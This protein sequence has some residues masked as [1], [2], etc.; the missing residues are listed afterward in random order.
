VVEAFRVHDT[1]EQGTEIG[2]R[3]R[4]RVDALPAR[5]DRNRAAATDTDIEVQPVLGR[6][7]LPGSWSAPS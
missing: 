3:A 2:Q 6:S 4:L 7:A 1:D 5:L